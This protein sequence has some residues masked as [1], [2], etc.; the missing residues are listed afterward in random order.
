NPSID[1]ECTNLYAGY[2]YCVA[3]VNGTSVTSTAVETSTTSSVPLSTTIASSS[4]TSHLSSTFT[5]A[6]SVSVTASSGSA[7]GPTQSGTEPQCTQWHTVVSGDYCYAIEQTYDIT[8]AQ[9]Q[10]WNPTIDSGCSNLQ[11]GYAYCVG[12]PES[13]ST[14]TLTSSITPMPSSTTSQCYT[15][16]TVVSGDY[17]YKIEQQFSITFD[18]FRTWNPTIDSQ[19]SNLQVGQ[20]YCVNASSAAPAAPES[21]SSTKTTSSSST[22]TGASTVAPPGP[23]GSGT[24]TACQEWYTVVSGDYCYKIYTQYGITF[25]QFRDWNGNVDSQCSNLVVGN[26]YCVSGP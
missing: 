1:A 14:L 20:S 4:L 12:A 2:D 8:F 15:W 23:T 21:A 26:A 18:Q 9:F 11:I 17:C 6:Q 7:P 5:I 25:A 19:C 16:Y 22:S 3:L 13:S 24:T 10:A